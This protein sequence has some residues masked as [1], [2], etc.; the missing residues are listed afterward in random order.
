MVETPAV[1][2]VIPLYNASAYIRGTV[3]AILE[4]DYSN[5]KVLI[6][7]DGSTDDSGVIARSIKDDRIVVWDQE[8]RGPGAAMNRAIEYAMKEGF[9]FIARADADDIMSPSRI[10]KQIH[11]LQKFPEVAACSANCYYVDELTEKKIGRS[12]VP[13]SA[14]LIEWE[15]KQGLRGLI[16]SATTFR[17]GTLN[18]IGGYR[19]HIRQAEDAD[20]FLRLVAKYPLLNCNDYLCSIRFRGDS[21][22]MGNV[23]LNIQ[24]HFYVLDCAKRRRKGKAEL[25]FGAFMEEID[26]YTKFLIWRE[27]QLLRYWRKGFYSLNLIYTIVA[28]FLDPRRVIARILRMIDSRIH[29][30]D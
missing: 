2:V 11:M 30:K 10:R 24:N 3:A 15:L 16:Q 29:S 26:G 5:F 23:R 8:N 18:D 9:P 22:S 21:L 20:L 14:K 27:E 28:A 13:I 25:D 19:P 4:Q 6:I 1:L 17:T 7:N 12:T